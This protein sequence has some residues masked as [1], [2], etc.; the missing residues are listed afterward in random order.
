MLSILKRWEREMNT[1]D[2]NGPDENYLTKEIK[3][4]ISQEQILANSYRYISEKVKNGRIKSRFRQFADEGSNNNIELLMARLKQILEY[5][6]DSPLVK[7][8]LPT[9]PNAFSLIGTLGLAEESE[10]KNIKIY[11]ELIFIDKPE[12]KKMY[13]GLIKNIGRR[14]RAINKEKRFTQRREL[15]NTLSGIGLFPLTRQGFI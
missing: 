10:K 4:A 5:E 11:K 1:L 7:P 8:G 6:Y 14:L 13:K 15:E 9:Q 3:A 2:K 12:Y